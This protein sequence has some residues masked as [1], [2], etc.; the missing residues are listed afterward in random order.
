MNHTD[1]TPE[2]SSALQALGEDFFGTSQCAVSV[3][4]KGT[5]K[6]AAMTAV[7]SL[8]YAPSSFSICH[9]EDNA[10][11]VQLRSKCPAKDAPL[12]SMSKERGVVVCAAVCPP[13][14]LKGIGVDLAAYRD[15]EEE[16]ARQLSLRHFFTAQEA[17]FLQDRT[18]DQQIQWCTATFSAKEA[19][20]KA[21]A[22]SVRAY[23]KAHP[24]AQVEGNFS[25]LEIQWDRTAGRVIPK[26]AMASLLTQMHLDQQVLHVTCTF[27][28][29]GVASLAKCESFT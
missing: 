8:G 16:K 24:G 21:L 20:V 29:N 2:D 10:P 14:S 26:G 1:Q 6:D 23:R 15:F 18:T 5:T 11:Y 25:D 4:T 28:E 22:P 13:D 27:S 3:L 17:L 12:V 7:R 9:D 19:A